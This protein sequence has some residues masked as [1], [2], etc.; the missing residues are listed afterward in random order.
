MNT[1]WGQGRAS[2]DL[3]LEEHGGLTVTL[4]TCIYSIFAKVPSS[5]NAREHLQN[6][7]YIY[8][9]F[10]VD[11]FS[12]ELWCSSSRMYISFWN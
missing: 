6:I 8:T 4:Y 5:V 12:S 2:V 1:Q 11:S 10:D 3:S 7:L 9:V